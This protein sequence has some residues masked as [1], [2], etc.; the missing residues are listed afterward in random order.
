MT[1]GINQTWTIF[2]FGMNQKVILPSNT[3]SIIL[4]FQR[5]SAEASCWVNLTFICSESGSSPSFNWRVA[6][7]LTLDQRN[8]F[9][10][11]N[12]T[13]HWKSGEGISSDNNWFI[14]LNLLAKKRQSTWYNSPPILIRLCSVSPGIICAKEVARW[15]AER[16][17]RFWTRLSKRNLWGFLSFRWLTGCF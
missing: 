8:F 17:E 2:G 14:F 15:N 4:C 6:L 13:L 10:N 11:N 3:R 16:S 9:W 7:R 12:V 5:R 1:A